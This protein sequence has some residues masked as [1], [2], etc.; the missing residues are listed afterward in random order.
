MNQYLRHAFFS[1]FTFLTVG[2][3]PIVQEAEQVERVSVC[4]IDRDFLGR[5][6]RYEGASGNLV[7]IDDSER[8]FLLDREGHLLVEV[9]QG[10]YCRHNEAHRDDESWEGESV[11]EA[12]LRTDP[13]RVYYAVVVHTGYEVVDHHS[14][15]GYAVTVYKPPKGFHLKGWVDE[16][17]RR[18]GEQ[19]AATLAEID[20]EK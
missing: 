18:A 13:N 14:I 3:K 7:D 16:Q 9:K 20:A 17:K 4:R 6:P 2:D 8:I 5:K 12:L 15:G 11:G 19:I 10:G 1:Q